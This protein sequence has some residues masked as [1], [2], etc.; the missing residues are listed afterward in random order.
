MRYGA[1]I[2]DLDGTL[3]NTLSDLAASMNRV[4]ARHGFPAHPVD[5]YRYFVGQGMTNLAKASVPDGTAVAEIEAVREEM[6]AD[7]GNNWHRESK[8][9]AGIPELLDALRERDIKLGILSNKPDPFTV[10]MIRHYFPAG[11]FAA[12]QGAREGVP[13]KPDPTGVRMMAET[14]GYPVGQVMYVGDTNTDMRTGLAA[15]MFTVGVTW[16]F[17]PRELE[18]SGAMAIVSKPDQLLGLLE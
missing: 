12:V 8:P 9:Y 7:Y 4:L 3:L 18:E 14:L 10:A 5:S 16:G 11:M 13:I 17:R 2:F 15:G 1:V 6:V